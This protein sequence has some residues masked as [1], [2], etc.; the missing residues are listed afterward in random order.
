MTKKIFSILGLVGIGVFGRIVPHLPDA[1]P[2]T[3]ITLAAQQHIGRVWAFV[4]PL[5]AMLI[6][7]AFIGFYSWRIMLA[8][9]AS[10]A[11]VSALSLLRAKYP[12]LRT[13]ALIVILSPV[14]FFLTTNFAVWI[15]SPW[16]A[17]NLAGLMYCYSLGLPFLRSMLIGDIA[18]TTIILGAF[19][20][21]RFMS[22]YR[23]HRPA[24]IINQAI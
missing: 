15:F 20:A 13:T 7:D 19:A 17:K 1:T 4:I 18:Y 12:G 24:A 5:A 8:V 3:A 23:V 6:S 16:Y 11:I 22:S 2:I 10:F 9:Y 21:V 14:I